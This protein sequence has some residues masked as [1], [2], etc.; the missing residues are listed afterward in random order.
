M[1]AQVLWPAPPIISEANVGT[2]EVVFTIM[3]LLDDLGNTV[4]GL[5][6]GGCLVGALK[7]AAR[8]QAKRRL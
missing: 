2:M 5:A 3:A 4:A 6:V 7:S 8:S 1:A